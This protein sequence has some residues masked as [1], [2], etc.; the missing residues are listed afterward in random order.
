MWPVLLTGTLPFA[1]QNPLS[2]SVSCTHAHTILTHQNQGY[3]PD[4]PTPDSNSQKPPS[5]DPDQVPGAL[6]K[7]FTR[8]KPRHRVLHEAA[9]LAAATYRMDVNNIYICGGDPHG[10][11]EGGGAGSSCLHPSSAPPGWRDSVPQP[12]SETIAGCSSHQ[13]IFTAREDNNG[14]ISIKKTPQ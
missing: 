8:V 3:A 9:N 1:S 11:L 13:S 6:C 4:N 7:S 14:N 10:G 12:E 5:Q 2:A